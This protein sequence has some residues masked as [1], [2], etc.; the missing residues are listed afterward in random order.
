MNGPRRCNYCYHS[1]HSHRW[2]MPIGY[3]VSR[4]TLWEEILENDV[5]QGIEFIYFFP[6]PITGNDGYVGDTHWV[7]LKILKN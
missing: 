4:L 2:A 1:G 5:N 6:F 3:I 7:M